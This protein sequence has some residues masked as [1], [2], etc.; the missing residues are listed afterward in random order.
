[1]LPYLFLFLYHHLLLLLTPTQNIDLTAQMPI[2]I[3]FE[4]L[5]L[6]APSLTFVQLQALKSQ[7]NF[8]FT[9]RH[10]LCC[11]YFDWLLPISPCC[12]PS[13]SVPL[14]VPVLVFS[15]G[16]G[17]VSAELKT[18]GDCQSLTNY[19]LPGCGSWPCYAP[20]TSYALALFFN[21]IELEPLTV[22]II[23][24]LNLVN[25]Q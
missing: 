12:Q 16:H 7:A 18:F 2:P 9:H 11:Y 23:C 21:W 22:S 25:S 8:I 20:I 19:T 6:L 13:L 3:P 24:P 10:L 1:M 4:L 5:I 14:A 15:I 17:K